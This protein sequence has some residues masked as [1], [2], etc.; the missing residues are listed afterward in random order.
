M[1]FFPVDSLIF[2]CFFIALM[3]MHLWHEWRFEK[4]YTENAYKLKVAIKYAALFK[5]LAI[6][7]TLAAVAFGISASFIPLVE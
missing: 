7:F 5:W 2:G 3:F 6:L 4:L 1:I